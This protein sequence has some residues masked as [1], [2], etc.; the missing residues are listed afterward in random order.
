MHVARGGKGQAA[1]GYVVDRRRER[2]R[3]VEPAQQL[4][5]P[6]ERRDHGQLPGEFEMAV[7][8]LGWAPERLPQGIDRDL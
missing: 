2:F 6:G 4:V 8:H 7:H 3:R 1:E 5:Q